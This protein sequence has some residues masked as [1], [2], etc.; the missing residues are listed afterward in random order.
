MQ[1][2]QLLTKDRKG[3]MLD[4]LFVI[5]ASFCAFTGAICLFL[6][7]VLD[8]FMVDYL[9]QLTSRKNFGT[10][11]KTL[12]GFDSLNE[13]VQAI[14]SELHGQLH[15]F[16][17]LYGVMMLVQGYQVWRTRITN[18]RVI[19]R[20]FVQASFVFCA[21]TLVVLV[22]G[23]LGTSHFH[24]LNWINISVFAALALAYLYFLLFQ[25]MSAFDSRKQH[26]QRRV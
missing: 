6:P 10:S 3:M 19:R 1:T 23:Q 15:M 12:S 11:T 26:M 5:H 16:I 7:H 24:M 20:T 2:L 8:I 21:L 22:I 4:V 25:P 14:Y 18:N 9:S 17:R 13:D